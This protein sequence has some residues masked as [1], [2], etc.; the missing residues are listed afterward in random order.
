MSDRSFAD[1]M[2]LR[3]HCANS[4]GMGWDSYTAAWRVS[5]ALKMPADTRELLALLVNG[6]K[7]RNTPPPASVVRYSQERGTLIFDWSVSQ[8]EIQFGI[9]IPDMWWWVADV[10][11]IGSAVPYRIERHNYDAIEIMIHRV[12]E[13]LK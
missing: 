12:A 6:L 10:G 8:L 3:R 7:E 11:E 1:R 9:D 4:G 5:M 13:G 2:R